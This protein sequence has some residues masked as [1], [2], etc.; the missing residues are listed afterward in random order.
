MNKYNNLRPFKD[1]GRTYQLRQW[2]NIVFILSA[3][4][5]MIVYFT[6]SQTVGL[7]II[8]GSCVLKFIELTLRM[9][10]L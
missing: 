2:M 7:Y 3:I 1:E 5:G 4:V 9:L 8:G 6:A 10:K